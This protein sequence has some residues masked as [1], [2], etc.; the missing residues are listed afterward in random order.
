MCQR[1]VA[2]GAGLVEP[3]DLEAIAL[4]MYTLWL[5]LQ[6]SRGQV[7]GQLPGLGGNV[8]ED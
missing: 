2:V 8:P 4:C 6:Q 1:L 3:M 5:R 7:Y